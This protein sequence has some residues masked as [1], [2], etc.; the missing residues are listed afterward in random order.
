MACTIAIANHKGGVGKTTT[1]YQLAHALAESVHARVL[2]CDLDP[3]AMLTKLL[4]F[5]PEDLPQTLHNVLAPFQALPDARGIV[6]GTE[7]SGVFLLPGSPDLARLEI[8]LATKI[9]RELTLRR[10][11]EPFSDFD[12]I[13]LD[14]PPDLNLLNTNALAA[15]DHVL[16]PVSTES[17]TLEALYDFRTTLEEVRRELNP[18]L[19][20]RIVVTKHEA[21]TSHARAMLEAL[22]KAYPAGLYRS[23]IPYSVVAK[24]A[25]AAHESVLT[26]APKSPVAEAYRR[27][28]EEIAHTGHGNQ[29]APSVNEPIHHA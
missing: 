14:C 13:L 19:T 5:R 18:H 8:Q 24:D 15:A 6:H 25:A 3:Q 7:M 20:D 10:A 27:L 11:L 29:V 4:N 22:E 16:I 23:V 2:L 26:F 21:K 28:A 17:M 12:F 9:N 1:S